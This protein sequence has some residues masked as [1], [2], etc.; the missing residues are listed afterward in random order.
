MTELGG[1]SSFRN[2]LYQKKLPCILGITDIDESCRYIGIK[3]W[4]KRMPVGRYGDCQ[5]WRMPVGNLGSL[6]NMEN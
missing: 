4:E 3:G 5:I 1:V 6:A 2:K